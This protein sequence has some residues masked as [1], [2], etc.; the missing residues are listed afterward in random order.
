MGEVYLAEDPVLG[1]RV[2]VK[3]LP[4][5]FSRDPERRERLLHEARAA[6]ALNHPNIVVVH[7]VGET[8]GV[9]WVAMEW[10]EGETLRTW[11]VPRRSPAEVLG[12]W[13]QI[14][15]ALQEAHAA[16]L[17]HRDLK[18]ENLMV[19]RDGIA[20]ILDFGLARS[21]S[22]GTMARTA[23]MPGVILGTAPYMSPEQVL[24]QPAGPSSDL[25]S[26]GTIFYE[27]LTGKHP[28]A[29]P[30]P[31]ET[32]HRILH[33]TP[34]NPSRVNG[35]LTS[36]FDFVLSKLLSKEPSRR[37]PSARDLDVDL[38]ILECGCLAAVPSRPA[39]GGQRSGS[40]PRAIAV[41][42]FKNIGGDRDLAYLGIGLADAL[43]TRL[44]TSPDLVV[45]ATASIARYEGQAVDPRHVGQELDVSAVLDASY[46]RAG[47]RFR[48][49]ARLVETPGG[50]AV[51][52]G[53]VDVRFEDIFDVQDQV[54]QG[55]AEALAATV[56]VPA[57]A[58]GFTP[59]PRAYDLVLRAARAS[60][61]ATPEAF[62][63]GVAYAE[64]AV[65]IQ[66]DYAH[67]WARYAE[68]CH[69]LVDGGFD[70]D[71]VWLEKTEHALR[72]AMELDPEEPLAQFV[73]G[74]FRLT[75]GRKREAWDALLEARRLAPNTPIVYHYLGY[76]FR[77]SDMLE[78]SIAAE[79]HGI[80]IDLS[81]PWTWFGLIRSLILLERIDEARQE[82]DRARTRFPGHPRLVIFEAYCVEFEGAH[83]EALDMTNRVPARDM[84]AG[85]RLRRAFLEAVLG[86]RDAAW[87]TVKADES[88][89]RIDMDHAAVGASIF[90]HL[91]EPDAAFELLHRATELGNDCLALYRSA[92]HFGPLHADVRWGPFVSGVERRVAEWKRSFQWPLPA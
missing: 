87:R 14:A 70:S 21:V 11:G 69:G 90:A 72:R 12:I 46:Q 62:R 52:A 51:W 64:Q 5:E 58:K 61:A 32:M 54:A 25:F 50:R 24:G 88:A 28:F 48:A 23:T 22:P 74:A 53:K 78:E 89:V 44:S 27:L 19:R 76:L 7:D 35:A 17:V 45:R 91:G 10:V 20:K 4:A 6:S 40:G 3:V 41:L 39:D 81:V 33:E 1:R 75:R 68:F 82:I 42:P 80:A 2:A 71:P 13:R 66:P 34:E 86:Q 31:V 37:H 79:R 92:D 16:S 67:A 9:L 84:S 38:E 36:D 73:L 65:E 63:E 43:I 30:T 49:T 77:L 18:P 59:D 47:D 85:D 56:T 8:G 15:R 29:A 60:N 83:R 57:A 26:L 55:I